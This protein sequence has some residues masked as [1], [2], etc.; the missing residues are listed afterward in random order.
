MLLFE[1]LI[2]KIKRVISESYQF[3]KEKI[4]KLEKGTRRAQILRNPLDSPI[5]WIVTQS[6]MYITSY[7][8]KY[9]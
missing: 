3:E 5:S 1:P 8:E 7:F 2:Q 4:F 6:L 9:C